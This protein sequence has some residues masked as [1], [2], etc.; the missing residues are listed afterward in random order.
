MP[1]SEPD[2][3]LLAL[4]DVDAGYGET[5][6]L[7]GISLDVR[8]GLITTLI[9]ANGAGKSTVLRTIFGILHPTRGEI[10]Y[11][12]SDITRTSS[13]SRLRNGV[14]Y[15]PQ[16]RCNFPLMTIQENLEM[17]AYVR[18]DADVRSDIEQLLELFPLL[19]QYR[20]ELAGNLSGGQQ[21]ILEMAMA[22]MPRPALLLIDEPSLG[23]SPIMLRQV[24]DHVLEINRTGVT[25]LMVE[26]NARQALAI[27]HYGIVLELGTVLVEDTGTAILENDEIRR[28]FLGR[29]REEPRTK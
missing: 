3:I 23:L 24:F 26:Q 27:S 28:R 6:V 1:T 5:P 13:T 4:N 11:R 25:V 8:E 22:L 16:G 9:G 10:L 18:S 15:C 19:R 2:H 29:T 17:G 14:T 12:G 21:Q 7:R 20:R